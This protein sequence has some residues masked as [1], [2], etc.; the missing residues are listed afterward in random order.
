MPAQQNVTIKASGLHTNN[1][2]FSSTPAGSMS[3]AVNVVI[4]RDEIVEP[5]RGFFQYAALNSMAKQLFN[6][7]DRVLAHVANTL[8]YDNGFGTMT[9][10][11]GEDVEEVSGL[12]VKSIEA[13]GNLYFISDEGVKK[14][15]ARTASDF[16]IVDVEFAGG[17]KA[18]DLNVSPDYTQFGWLEPNKA[19]A[20][21]MVFGKRDLNDN[22]I[23]GSVSS[24]AVVANPSAQACIASYNFS[25]PSTVKTGDFYQ[26]YRTPL[27]TLSNEDTTG[28]EMY[29]V[30]EDIIDAADILAGEI[31]DVDIT[32]ESFRERGALL[33]TNP[34]SGEGLTQSNEPPPFAKDICLYKGFTFLGNT[35]TIQRLNLDYLTINGI[36]STGNPDATTLSVSDGVNT[37]T[38]QYQGDFETQTVD[39]TAISSPNQF[40][41]QYNVSATAT[42]TVTDSTLLAGATID[43]N[44]SVLT[45]GA[46]LDW[47][48]DLG[49]DGEATAQSIAA[50]IDALPL[51]SATSVGTV[52][53]ITVD[54]QGSAGNSYT[55]TSSNTGNGLDLS[56]YP[57]TGGDNVTYAT[58]TLT[59]VDWTLLSG[60]SVTVNGSLPLVEGVDW[61][62][63][64]DNDTTATSLA[65]AIST[66]PDV[67]AAAVTNVI[68]VT[69]NT[70]GYIGN[71]YD[72]TTSDQTNLPLSNIGQF[73]GGI[74]E[75]VQSARY[76]TITSASDER[77]Y[78]VWYYR[79]AADVD[80]AQDPIESANVLGMIGVKVT[81]EDGDSIATILNNTINEIYVATGD[82]N[83]TLLGQLMTIEC[84]NNGAVTIPATIGNMLLL[85]VT[86]DGNGIGEDVATN[87][88]FLPRSTGE[89]APSVSVQLEQIGKSTVK[90]INKKDVLVNAYYVSGYDDVDGKMLL[91]HKQTT[92]AAFY[93]NMY[94]ADSSPTTVGELFNPTVPTSGQTV[95]SSNETRPN[96]IYYS[97]YQQPDAFPLTNY[98]DIGPKDREI[99]RIVPLR[100]ALFILKEDGIY[101]L[102]GDSA[103]AGNSN[104]SVQEFDFSA[105]VLAPDTAVVLNN[106]IYAL[107]TQGVCVISDTGVS[108]IS[109][110]IENQI[111]QIIKSGTEYKTLSFGIAYESDRSYHL[112]T[113]SSV[114]DELC[115][116]VFRYNNFT[117]TWTKF[118]MS[119]NCGIVNFADDK[120]YLGATDI[121]YVEK[122]RKTLN[123]TDHADREYPVGIKLNGVT[124][125]LIELTS[126]D[127]TKA[128]DVLY[129]RQYVTINQFN[130]ILQKLD[131]DQ[132]VADNNY[133][134]LLS[135]SRGQDLRIKLEG[136]CL[137]LDN[138]GGVNS[139]NYS[140]LIADI[141]QTNVTLNP[142]TSITPNGPQ[143]IIGF[144]SNAI[145]T[146]RWIAITGSDCVPSIDGVHEVVASSATTLT[147]NRE[148]T[149]AG[150]TGEA[151]TVVNNFRDIQHCFNAVVEELNNDTGVF[152][153]NY[154]LSTGFQDF[155]IIIDDV[156]DANSTLEVSQLQN[157]V[158]GEAYILNSIPSYFVYNPQ[159]MGDPSIEK[160]F[161]EGTFIFEDGNFSTVKVSYSSDKSPAY[162]DIKFIRSGGGDFG[163]FGFGSTNF[164]GLAAPIPLRTYVPLAKQ[165]GR[166]LAVRF[167]H[168]IAL[169]NYAL[170]GV[171]LN[172]R[173]YANRAYR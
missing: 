103:T 63:G 144:A 56:E 117:N 29:L 60:A 157:F 155:E 37:T 47:Q 75:I 169:E 101:K 20:Y 129:Q 145:Q 35:K 41:N 32:S 130:R 3:E 86:N 58:A 51:V 159:F 34:V 170:L 147:I 66:L 166:F 55:L 132:L 116:Q 148:I 73:S 164:G 119:K 118:D 127:N 104:F 123:R 131:Q 74:D 53:T 106:Q 21:R 30:Q 19:A 142:I 13:N 140:N 76:F 36:V 115:T 25:I 89:N 80:P 126:T 71:G 143:T 100:D 173:P 150:T 153:G 122:E 23:L 1:N 39:F 87:K 120:L 16:P 14:I 125:G 70:I 134:S 68:T 4:D 88:I 163:M 72:I 49:G 48:T 109:R 133:E 52:V 114:N 46:G 105:Q 62:A 85:A 95:I 69:A 154:L 44:G 136:L 22:L 172:F 94:A 59:V 45:E 84:S 139:T 42:I 152:F 38:Y 146:G 93:I 161:S 102:T 110:P 97:K 90:L 124:Q 83:I 138:D 64:V 160:Q 149:V 54:Q 158:F 167:D 113:V 65:A 162:D 141:S 11:S 151:Q 108:I 7:K 82:F 31:T 165:R 6:Y 67:T 99:K 2:Y 168:S 121:Y 18:V 8:V 40:V 50:A 17:V 61:T 27:A 9:A 128:G 111:L 77:Q 43:V 5:R 33:Y 156:D 137:K 96:R 135:M 78:Y 12:R 24:R 15:S 91:E 79:T 98:I 57:F 92:G 112:H 107:S 81:V 26:L 10:F 28:E 171:T